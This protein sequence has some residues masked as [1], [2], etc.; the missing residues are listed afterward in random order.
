MIIGLMNGV[1]CKPIFYMGKTAGW[2]MP[3]F[4]FPYSEDNKAAYTMDFVGI[5][6]I[7]HLKSRVGNFLK[8][9]DVSVGPFYEYA[10]SSKQN[11]IVEIDG[12]TEFPPEN[13]LN[14]ITD[15]NSGLSSG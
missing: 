10:L 13:F 8:N 11:W 2:G 4:P 5:S 1:C 15:I 9:F 14:Q 7:S 12:P 3:L 6:I